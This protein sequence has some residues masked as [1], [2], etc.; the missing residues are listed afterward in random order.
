MTEPLAFLNGRVMPQ[1]QAQLPLHDAGFVF[2]ATVTD[3]C[4]TFRHRLY[5]WPD[6]LAR[7]RHSCRTAYLDVPFEDATITQRAQ[8]LVAHNAGLIDTNGDLALVLFATPGP[9][10]YYLGQAVAAGE[11]PTFG[12]HTFALPFARYRPWIEQG[13]VLATPS[14]RQVPAVCVDPHVKQR[15]RMHWWLAEQELRH[16]HPGAQA[17]LLDLDG[18]VTE[19]ASA[20]FLLVRAGTI[21]APPRVSVLEGISLGVVAELCERLGIPIEYRH[22]TLAECYAADE[23]LLTCTSYCLAGVRQIND[24]AI[25]GPG[26]MLRRL[27]DAWNAAVGVDIHQQILTG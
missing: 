13:V 14:V 6:H 5:R 25:P 22:I 18:N 12:M 16:T 21:V 10:G 15:S 27:L 19:T 24:R 9:V 26:P 23:A 2:G 8:E 11:Q 7:F 1:S 17:L 3:L 4:R 20:N